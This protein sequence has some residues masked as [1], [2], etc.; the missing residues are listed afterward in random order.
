M[1]LGIS[2]IR[3]RVDPERAKIIASVHDSVILEVRDDY[4]EEVLPIIKDC[5]ENPVF[6]GKHL[7]FLSIPLEADFEIGQKYGSMDEIKVK[8]IT[9]PSPLLVD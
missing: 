4:I 5:L 3:R 2:N 9:T 6:K 1:M 7:S 8:P